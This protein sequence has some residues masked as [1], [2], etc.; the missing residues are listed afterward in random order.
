MKE[1]TAPIQDEDLG[2]AAAVEIA[3]Y[4]RC[5]DRPLARRPRPFDLEGA[6]RRQRGGDR[7]AAQQPKWCPGHEA[8]NGG[9]NL[10]PRHGLLSTCWWVSGR[11]ECRGV[12]LLIK[13]KKM[14]AS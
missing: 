2:L 13:M 10:R 5:L 1:L 7:N 8:M 14:L 12:A 6:A 4:R 9:G 3:H 11:G